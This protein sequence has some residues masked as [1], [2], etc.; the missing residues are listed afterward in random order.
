MPI[1]TAHGEGQ[2]GWGRAARRRTA[3]PVAG[4]RGRRT[5]TTSALSVEGSPQVF[6]QQQQVHR[7]GRAG[8]ELGQAW[9]EVAG[10]FGPAVDEHRPH[11]DDLCGAGDAAQRVDHQRLAQYCPLGCEIDA[12]PGQDHHRLMVAAGSLAQ[13]LQCVVEDLPGVLV[14]NG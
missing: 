10:C 12:E 4:V 6:H 1:G 5:P 11:A 7:V 9:V 8:L 2:A 3:A 13:P 14:Q